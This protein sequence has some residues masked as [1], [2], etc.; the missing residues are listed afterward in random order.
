MTALALA[1]ALAALL[2]GW[3]ATSGHHVDHAGCAFLRRPDGA[4]VYVSVRAG[5][6]FLRPVYPRRLDGTKVRPDGP[7]LPV[8]LDARRA[9]GEAA[10]RLLPEYLSNL[11]A[12][13]C[14]YP[15]EST[16]R[17]PGG[18]SPGEAVDFGC[19]VVTV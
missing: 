14:R 9:A 16:V 10:R 3:H 2:P 13:A 12:E 5:A 8:P 6:A 19:Q 18:K 15:G 11:S 4:R 7:D 17:L 1:A